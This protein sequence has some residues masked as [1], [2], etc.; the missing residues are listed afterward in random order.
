[1]FLDRGR[2]KRDIIE[3]LQKSTIPPLL[4]PKLPGPKF[5][6]K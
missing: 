6:K 5:L 1:M 4:Y 3:N 2:A